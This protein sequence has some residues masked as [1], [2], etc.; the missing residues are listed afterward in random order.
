MIH[1]PPSGIADTTATLT[2]LLNWGECKAG[3]GKQNTQVQ[4]QESLYFFK[5]NSWAVFQLSE[6]AI[7]DSLCLLCHLKAGRKEGKKRTFI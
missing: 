7:S 5:E 6:T 1:S 4:I 2:F 3:A